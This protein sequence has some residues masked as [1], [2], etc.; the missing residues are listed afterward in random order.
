MKKTGLLI[1]LL[2]FAF[3]VNA[4]QDKYADVEHVEG[5]SIYFHETTYNFG[6]VPEGEKR[7]HV[8]TFYNNG[9]EPVVISRV[10]PS[11]GCTVSE[12]T[13]EPVAPGETGEIHAEYNSTNRSGHFSTQ[14]QVTSTADNGPHTLRIRGEVTR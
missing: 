4:A 13:R 2:L 3:I 7:K 10:R 11:C 5:S 12:Y 6:S 1:V 9:T 8:F 14:I